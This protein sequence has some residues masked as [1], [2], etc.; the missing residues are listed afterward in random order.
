LIGADADA[1]D[2]DALSVRDVDGAGGASLRLPV[3]RWDRGDLSI[4]DDDVAVEVPCAFV[5]NGRPF[6]VMLA[7]PLDLEDLALGFCLTEGVV[8]SPDEFQGVEVVPETRGYSVYVSVPKERSEALSQRERAIAGRTGCGLCGERMLENAVRQAPLVASGSVFRRA[9]VQAA[10]GAVAEAQDI[11]RITGAVHAA[12][13]I[14]P[15]G[16]IVVIREDIGRHNALDKL[17]GA[18]VRAKADPSAGFA[19]VTSRASYE[20]V[21]KAAVFGAPMLVAVSA[22][23]A[24]AVESAGSAGLTLVGFARPGRHAVYSHA[25]RLI[26]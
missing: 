11:N 21:H 5:V 19:F 7:S 20:M 22:P 16:R 17:I 12:A 26:D 2:G 18:L 4:V 9:A 23:T 15:D 3:E 10:I 1:A 13:W 24:L 8:T 14:A 25:H 6:A